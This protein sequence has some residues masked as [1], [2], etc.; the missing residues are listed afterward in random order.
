MPNVP[1]FL[2]I[3][4]YLTLVIDVVALWYIIFAYKP[5]R[6]RVVMLVTFTC[7]VAIRIAVLLTATQI[8]GVH[9]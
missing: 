4:G 1:Q 8:L 7:L 5:E 3:T 9:L 6:L 2:L